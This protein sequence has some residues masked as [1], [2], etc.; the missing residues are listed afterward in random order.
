MSNL[1]SEH[2]I[3][4]AIAAEL[5]H[6]SSK[7]I[8]KELRAALSAG[9]TKIALDLTAVRFLNSQALGRIWA[10]ANLCR[11]CKIKFVVFGLTP[12]VQGVFKA[13]SYLYHGRQIALNV[14]EAI[15][16]LNG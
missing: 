16:M 7:Q 1:Q 11:D 10:F 5:D 4:V 12:A 15:E 3:I 6:E 2:K 8:E 9:W 13:S 14:E